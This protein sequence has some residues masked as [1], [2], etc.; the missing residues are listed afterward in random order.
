CRECI[1][2]FP[3]STQHLPCAIMF[4]VG[5]S[6]MLLIAIVALVVIGPERLP[7]V[8]RTMGHLFARLQRYVND[9]K[10]DINREMELDELRKFKSEFEDAAQSVES[11]FRSE[12]SSAVSEFDLITGELKTSKA[13]ESPLPQSGDT[14]LAAAETSPAESPIPQSSDTALPAAET[15][16]AEPVQA[17]LFVPATA[18][19]R[20]AHSAAGSEVPVM[21]VKSKTAA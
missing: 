4:D 2:H 9:V 5:F 18:D 3:R 6:E 8:A 20:P 13:A 21:P 19:D 7:K 15:A 16:A 11:T 10:A 17:D 1:R 12:A 14:V